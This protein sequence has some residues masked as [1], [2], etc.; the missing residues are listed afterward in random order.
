[1]DESRLES[2]GGQQ[3]IICYYDDTLR[4]W[5]DVISRALNKFKLKAGQVPVLCLPKKKRVL[6]DD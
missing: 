5:D 3:Y 6:P 2:N 1:M 4:N